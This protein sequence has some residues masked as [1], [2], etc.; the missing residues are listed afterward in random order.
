V[1]RPVL[2]LDVDGVFNAEVGHMRELVRVAMRSEWV[3]SLTYPVV[4][5]NGKELGL[6]G[7]VSDARPF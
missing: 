3:T 2:A 5:G 6:R 4:V 7:N 1:T